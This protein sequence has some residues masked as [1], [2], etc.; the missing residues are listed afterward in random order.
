MDLDRDG[1]FTIAWQ[2]MRDLMLNMLGWMQT[3]TIGGVPILYINLGFALL[4]TLFAILLP[5]IRARGS[6]ELIKVSKNGF[7]VKPSDKD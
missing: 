7:D 6:S 4:I 2:L 3:V 5:V 1:N